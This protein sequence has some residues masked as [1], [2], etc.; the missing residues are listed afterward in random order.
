MTRTRIVR[1]YINKISKGKTTLL[2]TNG[3]FKSTAARSNIWQGKEGT[4]EHDHE[5]GKKKDDE[6]ECKCK[7]S[8]RATSFKSLVDLVK[9]AEEMLIANGQLE[10]ETRI[11]TIR[12]I[13]YGTTWSLDY[14]V[15]KSKTRIRGFNL[16]T[17]CVV[18]YDARVALKCT[19]KCKAQL[20]H[21]LYSSYEIHDSHSRSLDFGHLIIG[22]DSRRS[23]LNRYSPRGLE[24]NTWVGDLGGGVGTLSK[25][26]IANKNRRASTIFEGKHSYGA[27]SNLEGDIAAYVV[28][29]DDKK[30]NDIV[31]PTTNFGSIHEALQDYF[32]NKWQRRTFYFL[33]MLGAKVVGNK[34]IYRKDQLVKKCSDKF[35][36]FALQYLGVRMADRNT[37]DLEA[38][39]ESSDNFKTT[40]E[41][42]ASIFVDALIH[43][44]QNPQDSIAA[45]IDPDPGKSE[46]T[47]ISKM[48]RRSRELY[49]K[50]IKRGDEIYRGTKT[51]IK[52][53]DL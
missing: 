14:A 24:N 39:T 12:G 4:V 36:S 48:Y 7:V 5:E 10:M 19:E 25:Q 13:Y 34:V 49:K 9:Q 33:A 3:S 43:V 11:N 16:Y 26:R 37:G 50:S 29:M 52:K 27:V 41:E 38:F 1:G 6:K 23:I 31:N 35:E 30:P 15:E 45:R 28:G 2:V 18:K 22:L 20:F 8:K 53:M 42:I 17:N 51:E 47:S 44:V 46:E 32:A 40:A 21:S